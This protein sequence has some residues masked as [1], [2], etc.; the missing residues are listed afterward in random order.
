MKKVLKN[1]IAGFLCLVL[2]L[3]LGGCNILVSCES[4]LGNILGGY[5]YCFKKST[6]ALTIGER[7]LVS[8]DDFDFDPSAPVDFD[9]TLSTSD[10]EV[11]GVSGKTVTAKKEGSAVL[12]ADNGKESVT[13]TVVVTKQITSFSLMTKER[14]KKTTDYRATDI[15]AVINDGTLLADM[16]DISWTVDGEELYYTGGSYTVAPSSVSKTTEI[17]ATLTDKNGEEY[18]DAMRVCYYDESPTSLTLTSS[19]NKEQS[20]EETSEVRYS[21][22]IEEQTLPAISW[23]VNGKEEARDCQTFN[24]TPNAV[25]EYKISA[26]VNG[27]ESE[28]DKI[29]VSGSVTPTSVS[30]DFDTYYPS[31]L[32][33]FN[34][35]GGEGET[36]TVK[37]EQNNQIKTIETSENQVLLDNSKLDIFDT[38]CKISVKS[39]GNGEYLQESEYSEEVVIEKQTSTAKYYLEK[40]WFGGN[41]YMSSDEEVYAIYDYFMLYRDQPLNGSTKSSH[42]VYMGYQSDYTV[43]RLS[44]IAFDR[45]GYTGSYDISHNSKTIGND[46]TI[47]FEFDFH[48]LSTPTN[49][50]APSGNAFNGRELHIS[51]VGMGDAPLYI[52]TIKKTATVSTTDQLYRVAELGYKPLPQADGRAEEYYAYAKELLS[53]IL[54]E[55]MSDVE[56]AHAIYDWIMWRVS[57]DSAASYVDEIEDAVK[58]G[59]FYIEGVLTDENY[60]AVCDGMSKTYSLLCNMAGLPCVRVTGYADSGGGMGGH[61]WNKVKVDGEWYV[62]D[63]TWGDYETSVEYYKY[64]TPFRKTLMSFSGETASH[65][66]FL[67]TD[68]Q[69]SL[70][71]EEDENTAY[72]KTSPLPYNAYNESEDLGFVVSG[73]RYS[74]YLSSEEQ[75]SEYA[76]ALAQYLASAFTGNDFTFSIGEREETSQFAVFEV[77]L[78]PSASAKIKQAI[79]NTLT[80]NPFYKALN[81]QNLYSAIFLSGYNMKVIVSKTVEIE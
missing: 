38:V 31:V 71:H 78:A 29:T 18:T 4:I 54:D 8:E 23:L 28:T 34:S 59:A 67:L 20:I 35:L 15:Y 27:T 47:T 22:V 21:L 79:N 41:Y 25:G 24:F 46:T 50:N 70:T 43:S 72:P 45:A 30:A 2:L 65:E 75:I 40:T 37:V 51:S 9:F 49:T 58:L 16:F 36:Y 63:C 14:A 73:K 7:W 39:N 5:E 66:Y 57:Y 13:C 42:S 74:A 19:G 48:T 53:Q 11:V 64:I 44:Q 77:A 56:I 12:T 80:G 33:S 1:L 62:V 52:D 32:V 68:G 61:A 3:S 17:I 60:T 81:K 6:K 26:L 55:S 76:T 10:F 69:I